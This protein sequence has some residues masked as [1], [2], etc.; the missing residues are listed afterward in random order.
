MADSGAFFEKWQNSFVNTTSTLVMT[1][2][3]RVGKA[4][5]YAA[6]KRSPQVIIGKQ[7]AI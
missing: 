5:A 3:D 6:N 1:C 4:T 7:V 2:V